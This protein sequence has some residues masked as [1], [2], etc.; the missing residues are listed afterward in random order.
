MLYNDRMDK[1]AALA[2]PTRRQIIEILAREGELPA[3]EISRHFKISPQAISQHLKT[4]R[5]A[6]LVRVEKRAQQRIYTI[7]PEV[8]YELEEWAKG[9]RQLWNQRFDAFE[10]LLLAEKRKERSDEP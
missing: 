8:M 1:F 5:A 2:D 3:A 9:L 4:L 6:D 10:K 7:N